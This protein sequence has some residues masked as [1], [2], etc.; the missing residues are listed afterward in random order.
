MIG[1]VAVVGRVQE[2]RFE[3]EARELFVRTGLV[4]GLLV[5]DASTGD[6]VYS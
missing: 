1:I 2:T 5:L 3:R 6:V 4:S